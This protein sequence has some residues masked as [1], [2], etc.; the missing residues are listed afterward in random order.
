MAMNDD[1]ALL[2]PQEAADFL[3]MRKQT[4]ANWRCDGG[5]P[6]FARFGNRIF[7]PM[8]K[9]RAFV[10]TYGSTSEYGRPH[11]PPIAGAEDP[12]K[13]KKPT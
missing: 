1:E 9:V 13:D 4:L 2:S 11:D 6:E 7:Y 8:R 5:G 12:P 10:R 3:R